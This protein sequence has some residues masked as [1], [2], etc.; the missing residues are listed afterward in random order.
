MDTVTPPFK[1]HYAIQKDYVDLRKVISLLR[2]DMVIILLKN[3]NSSFINFN[4]Q[5]TITIN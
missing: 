3:T 2:Y 4:I 1:L 5:Y